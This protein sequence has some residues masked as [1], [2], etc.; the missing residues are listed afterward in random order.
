MLLTFRQR[1][2]VTRASGKL[3]GHWG[4]LPGWQQ[5]GGALTCAG[6]GWDTGRK[7]HPEPS[8]SIKPQ[9]SRT[10]TDCPTLNAFPRPPP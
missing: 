9:L 10:L 6:E 1:V 4:R 3:Q 8:A 5:R 7:G 2:L